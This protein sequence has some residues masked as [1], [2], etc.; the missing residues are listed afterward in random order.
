MV[1]RLEDNREG[2]GRGGTA[3]TRSPGAND[4]N[5]P[6]KSRHIS[7]HRAAEGCSRASRFRYPFS[8][9]VLAPFSLPFSLPPFPTPLSFSLS[10]SNTSA[11]QHSAD[12]PEVDEKFSELLSR[13]L[14]RRAPTTSRKFC[15][16]N[17]IVRRTAEDPLAGFAYLLARASREFIGHR[18][19]NR[20]TSRPS[21]PWRFP[22]HDALLLHGDYVHLIA[23]RN[24]AKNQIISRIYLFLFER[25]VEC[26]FWFHRENKNEGNIEFSSLYVK[27]VSHY[28]CV[29]CHNNSASKYDQHK[30]AM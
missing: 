20:R 25:S 14:S 12:L 2:R 17:A 23:R 1:G 19:A 6:C 30:L 9:V 7:R 26:S 11:Q 10:L 29:F 24:A 27:I 18:F 3:L 16:V 13:E 22:L 5:L 28:L 21:A 8:P 4:A 15:D